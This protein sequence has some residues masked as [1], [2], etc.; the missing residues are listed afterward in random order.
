M[1]E[2]QSIKI[3]IR[4]TP[5]SLQ[6]KIVGFKNECLIVKIKNAP[7]NNA[8]NLAIIDLFSK[9][10]G[11]AKNEIQIVNG[12]KNKNKIIKIITTDSK[13]QTIKNILLMVNT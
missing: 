10:F 2:N 7:I 6:N 9:E 5:R 1:L 11:V 13:I 8:V 12:L 4:V 3:K